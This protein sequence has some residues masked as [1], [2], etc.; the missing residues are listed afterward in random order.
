MQVSRKASRS[1]GS[2]V[3]RAGARLLIGYF[4]STW[5]LERNLA[6]LPSLP[7]SA[8]IILALFVLL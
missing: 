8:A 3:V 7:W 2:T 4:T 1:V 5:V 6:W